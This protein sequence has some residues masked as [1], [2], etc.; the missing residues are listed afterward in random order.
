MSLAS[1]PGELLLQVGA[2]VAGWR[3]GRPAHDFNPQPGRQ[4]DRYPQGWLDVASSGNQNHN[5]FRSGG[6]RHSS[7][8]GTVTC[9]LNPRHRRDLYFGK[10]CAMTIA[11][12]LLLLVQGRVA[13]QCVELSVGHG[14]AH[15]CS[16]QIG[17]QHG[18]SGVHGRHHGR[19]VGAPGPG[20]FVPV[21]RLA[22]VGF[23]GV[24]RQS[25][26]RVAL[27]GHFQ[28]HGRKPATSCEIFDGV[29]MHAL[30]RPSVMLFTEQQHLHPAVDIGNCHRSGATGQPER[31]DGGN[32]SAAHVRQ[33]MTSGFWASSA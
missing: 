15:L 10:Q 12:P 9:N 21:E 11:D 19:L 13:Q 26:G 22:H 5:P 14:G 4:V 23:L 27:F 31:R 24:A 16:G 7:R 30:V 18:H 2:V 32:R 20:F 33:C 8:H 6:P 17:A 25:G 3:L 28:R 1:G 29:A